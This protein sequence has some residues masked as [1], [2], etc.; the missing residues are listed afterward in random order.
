MYTLLKVRVVNFVH[1]EV[2]SDSQ[3]TLLSFPFPI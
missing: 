2:L 3:F 1:A